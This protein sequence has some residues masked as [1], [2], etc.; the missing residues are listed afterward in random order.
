[1]I[2]MSKITENTLLPLSLVSILIGGIFWLSTMY[3][4]VEA[5]EDNLNKIQNQ[6]TAFIASDNNFKE[7]VIDRLARI[8]TKLES[9][10][11]K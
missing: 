10:P 9:K 11:K 8:E 4:K 3:S 6:Q 5:H 1:M 7:E 2:F